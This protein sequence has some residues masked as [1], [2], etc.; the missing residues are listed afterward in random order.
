MFLRP[1]FAT[2][3]P[4]SWPDL[5]LVYGSL[6]LAQYPLHWAFPVFRN[7]KGRFTTTL[8]KLQLYNCTP[9]NVRPTSLE[10][11]EVHFDNMSIKF[12]KILCNTAQRS[13]D[14]IKL[15]DVS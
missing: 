13:D 6:G 9:T 8:A 14:V 7:Q 15:P 12:G 1:D 2:R 5:F 11:Y 3:V 4:K 10:V